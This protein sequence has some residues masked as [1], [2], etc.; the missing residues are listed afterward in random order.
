VKLAP[1]SLEHI[2]GHKAL[3]FHIYADDGRLLLPAHTRLDDARILERLRQ[4]RSLFVQPTDYDAWRR[5]MARAV[6]TM[7]QNNA[8]LAHLAK[9]RSDPAWL[10]AQQRQPGDLWEQ[11]VRMLS[12]NMQG[13]GTDKPWVERVLEV[14]ARAR[15]LAQRRREEA[16]FHFIYTGGFMTAFYSARQALRSML[17]VGDVARELQWEESRIE[18]L[19]KAALTMNVGMWPLQDKLVTLTGKALSPEAQALIDAH[20]VESARLLQEGGVADEDWLEA[21]RLHGDENLAARPVSALSPGQ[22]MALL[23]QR[24]ERYGVLISRR[25][26]CEALSPTQAAQQVCLAPDGR[27]DAMGSLLLKAMGLYPP[28]S[29]VAL[30]SNEVGIVLA[31]G[32]HAAQPVVAALRNAQ[33]MTMAEPRLRY[34]SQ[35]QLAVRAAL[36]PHEA[37]ADPPLAKLQA[38]RTFM[39]SAASMAPASPPASPSGT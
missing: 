17:I 26:G 15:E 4:Q 23:L 28:G 30:A 8:P 13:A 14:H 36:R 2:Q 31:R 12:A 33:G 18:L 35:P 5:G 9:V 1:L 29:F 24:V 25:A 20:P 32:D 39:K 37:N 16:L 19:E 27:P 34:T 7:L 11:L 10:D 38:L 6:D 21:V 3:P 22:Q